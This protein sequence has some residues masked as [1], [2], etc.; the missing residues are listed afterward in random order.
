[1]FPGRTM[2]VRLAV[3]LMFGAGLIAVGGG[4]GDAALRPALAQTAVNS[5][6]ADLR[7]TLDRVLGEHVLIVGALLQ[8]TYDGAPD[9]TAAMAA[10]DANSVDVANTVST[11]YGDAAAATFLA[12]WRRH[13]QDYLQFTTALK[14]GDSAGISQADADLQAYANDAAMQLA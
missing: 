3:A 6:A 2:V 8:K 7:L 5:P 13:I 11:V 12:G 14:A 10:T 1:M 9:A 4:R